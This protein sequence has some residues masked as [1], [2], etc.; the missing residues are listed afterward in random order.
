MNALD[1]AEA[2]KLA[3]RDA[4]WERRH[5]DCTPQVVWQS[6][7]RV[8]VTV[9]LSARAPKWRAQ[10]AGPVRG[11]DGSELY[12]LQAGGTSRENVLGKILPAI[13]EFVA[14]WPGGAGA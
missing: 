6:D 10:A 9:W 7:P 2:I 8:E 5:K 12:I 1:I 14:S 11:P 3:K 13:P 4:A